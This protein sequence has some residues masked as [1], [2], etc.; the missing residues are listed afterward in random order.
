MVLNSSLSAWMG[1]LISENLEQSNDIRVNYTRSVRWKLYIG[2][3]IFHWSPGFI[4]VGTGV[5][6]HLR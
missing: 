4:I 5:T 2:L 3:L 1:K 6:L